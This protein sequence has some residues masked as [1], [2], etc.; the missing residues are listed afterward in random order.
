MH[1]DHQRLQVIKI[2]MFILKPL[3]ISYKQ[4]YL[5]MNLFVYKLKMFLTWA[6]HLPQGHFA[7]NRHLQHAYRYH[8]IDKDGR[9]IHQTCF[10]I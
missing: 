10:L 9:S 6:W 5:Q 4:N 2:K 7:T 1:D 3:R 8:N